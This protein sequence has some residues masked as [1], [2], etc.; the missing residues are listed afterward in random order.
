MGASYSAPREAD[1]SA[2][3]EAQTV[4]FKINIL[5]RVLSASFRE[6]GP[7]FSYFQKS[8]SCLNKALF[9]TTI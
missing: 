8:L 5:K 4:E 1:K 3:A 7:C 9:L 6:R 2:Q